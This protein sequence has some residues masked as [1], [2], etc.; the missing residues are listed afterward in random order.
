MEFKLEVFKSEDNSFIA[1]CPKLNIYSYGKT[2]DKAITR[3]RE[4]VNFYLESAD[5][6]GVTLEEL[7]SSSK[8]SSLSYKKEK[9][10]FIDI[11]TPSRKKPRIN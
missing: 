4:V 2:L 7:C 5:E 3:L 9:E 11:K 8:M 1:T 6:L 10:G